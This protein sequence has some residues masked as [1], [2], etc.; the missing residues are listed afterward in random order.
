[1]VLLGLEVNL[2]TLLGER[3]RPAPSRPDV[4]PVVLWALPGAS[5][6]SRCCGRSTTSRCSC[7]SRPASCSRCCQPPR[8]AR[9]PRPRGHGPGVARALA[10]LASGALNTSTSTGGPPVVLLLAPRAPAGRGPRHADRVLHRL[11]AGLGARA[12]PHGHRG[13]DPAWR[14]VAL[15]VP[16]AAA[17][18]LAGGAASPTSRRSR[19]LRARADRGAARRGGGGAGQRAVVRRAAPDRRRHRSAQRPGTL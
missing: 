16:L 5:P 9:R 4:L 12:G 10:G 2:L 3:R 19:A 1:M 14:S 18:A 6:A 17:G 7:S 11:R 15:F 13:R 8:R